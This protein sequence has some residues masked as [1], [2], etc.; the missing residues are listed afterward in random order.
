[1]NFR[2]QTNYTEKLNLT[3]FSARK[4]NKSFKL[5]NYINHTNCATT[6]TVTQ[7]KGIREKIDVQEYNS[8]YLLK[9][10]EDKDFELSA[11]TEAIEMTVTN[12]YDLW[13][14][15][16]RGKNL[17]IHFLG[18]EDYFSRTKGGGLQIR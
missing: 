12:T 9:K 2:G 17:T 10:I 5:L 6:V 8:T 4:E 15:L 16:E 3:E 18:Y 1:M 14:F 13:N 7:I 11:A